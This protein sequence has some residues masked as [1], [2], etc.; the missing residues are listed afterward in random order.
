MGMGQS[1]VKSSPI[2]EDTEER[3]VEFDVSR[4][5]NWEEGQNSPPGKRRE[6]IRRP[7]P[8]SALLGYKYPIQSPRSIL[9]KMDYQHG[10][11]EST[12]S[13]KEKGYAK[14]PRRTV[15][16]QTGIYRISKAR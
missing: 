5:S 12:G 16:G 15:D 2:F 9:R 11:T 14:H 3:R 4:P 13:P 6:E 10:A 7:P 1:R 8:S